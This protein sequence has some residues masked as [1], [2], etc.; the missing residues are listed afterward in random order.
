MKNR[1]LF[2]LLFCLFG[3]TIRA[4]SIY[5][6]PLNPNA[7]WE[8]QTP[9]SLGWCTDKIDSLYDFLASENTKAFLV[10]KDGKIVLEKYFGTFTAD[11]AWYWA[12]AGKTLTSFLV[13]KA[14]EEGLL[15][16][17]DSTQAYLGNGW[18]VCPPLKE[19]KIKVW[20]QLTMTSGLNDGIPDYHCTDPAC[21]QYLADAGTRW[22]YHNAPYTLLDS[23]L[24]SAT[25][26]NL[27]QL[28]TQKLKT[29]TGMTG[30]W[31]KSGWNNLYVST[32][33]SMAR[34]GLAVQNGFRWNT[35]PLLN[36]TAFARQSLETSQSLNPSYGYLWWLNGKSSYKV[37]GS[38][39]NFSGPLVP[40]AP[41]D[42]VSAIGKNGQFLSISKST[43][44]VL[45]RMGDASSSLEVPFLLL[46]EIWK[47]F[48]KVR[49]VATGN[50]DWVRE[51]PVSL[52]PNPAHTA[53]SV[54]AAAG[55]GFRLVNGWGQVLEEGKFGDEVNPLSIRHLPEGL[56]QLQI[57][58]P[59]Q[60][61]T[62]RFQK[63]N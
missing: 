42:L 29:L 30:I 56:Y 15:K 31:V 1:F 28:T 62:L 36:D 40:D 14:R 52:Y 22:A 54:R 49:C 3:S 60:I 59:G 13:G 55:S 44:L 5:F 58:T 24:E 7:N 20:N 26:K 21:L 19:R 51:N 10:L 25:G 33:R 6:P 39:I 46:G 53:L 47:H 50:E 45:V 18:T 4:Q 27:N 41:M 37:P 35:T 11:S 2:I 63:A 61:R 32:P 38:Q 17:E 43:G 34:F 16:L 8:S 23:V 48:N 57:Q 9:A 12:S